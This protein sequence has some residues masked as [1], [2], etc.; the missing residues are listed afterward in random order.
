MDKLNI[1]RLINVDFYIGLEDI[2]R[3]RTF[4]WTDDMSVL[5]ESLKLQIFNEGQPNNN[6]GNEYC[7]QY[8]VTFAKV[9]D[10]P[11]N[12][13]SNVVCENSCFLF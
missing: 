8:S 2:G 6:L 1:A 9:H 5:D 13:N 10:V 4:F 3:N 11:C 12:W 7:V